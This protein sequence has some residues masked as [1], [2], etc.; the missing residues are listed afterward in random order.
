MKVYV[1]VKAC[2]RRAL[3]S[4]R[5]KRYFSENNH[6]VVDFPEDAEL[7][8]Y[9]TCAVFNS[10]V[11]YALKK[12][13]EFQ[14]YDAELIV[15]GCL[16]KINKEEL[17]EIFNGRT[18]STK[19]IEKID[20]FFPEN[21][22]KFRNIEDAN[23]F[24]SDVMF[25]DVHISSISDLIK[26]ICSKIK[27]LEEIQIKIKYHVLDHLL[28]EQSLLYK[29]IIKPKNP[30]YYIRISRGCMGNCSYCGIKNAN[31]LK[32]VFLSLKKDLNRV[33]LILF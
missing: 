9:V 25:D 29:F 31:L 2:E 27:L 1:F 28:G 32:N 30:R 6:E 7:I 5:Y 22:I 13:K 26:Q 14:K 3:D 33:I 20:D 10:D 15:A 8:I 19:D 16:P 21:K 23:I 4:K 24:S 17:S 18:I 11:D 12:I